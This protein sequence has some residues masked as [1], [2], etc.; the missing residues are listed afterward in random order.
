LDDIE[1]SHDVVG[2]FSF[3]W[4]YIEYDDFTGWY[5]KRMMFDLMVAA[6][7]GRGKDG[8]RETGQGWLK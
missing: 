6:G 4:W 1:S 7:F 8:W 2:F 5:M 3:F